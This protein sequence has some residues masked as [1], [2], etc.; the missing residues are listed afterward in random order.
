[1][2]KKI[3][4]K[5]KL[6]IFG[7]FAKKYVAR[8]SVSER[9]VFAIAFIFLALL[10]V[11]YLYILIWT[12][13]AGVKSNEEFVTRPFSIPTEWRFGNFLEVFDILI[14][15]DTNFWGMLFNSLYWSLLGGF[16][17][18]MFTSMIA[19][20]AA[21]YK[22]PGSGAF[23]VISMIMIMLPI[24]GTGGV[25]YELLYKLGFVDSYT[26]IFTHTGGLGMLFLYFYAGF[27]SVSNAY[28]E[29]AEIDG[30][31]E[32]QIYFKVMFPQV[33]MLFGVLYLTTWKT[34]WNDFSSGLIYMRKHPSIAVGIYM[35]EIDVLHEIRYDVLYA[36]Y[37]IAAIPPILLF[38]IFNNALTTNVSLGGIKE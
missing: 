23:Y 27:S 10:A 28:K 14:V 12:F 30:A 4:I 3:K 11:S 31:N 25:R 22:F 33:I 21:K 20:I 15:N 38:T 24:Y 36:A 7:R 26:E 2:D 8:R 9:I 16:L 35:F 1:M 13:F 37:F 32:W 6:D 29:A 34:A 5:N 17:Q 18:C 19:Y